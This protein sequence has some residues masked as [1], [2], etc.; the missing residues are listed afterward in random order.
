M[1]SAA[2]AG[3]QGAAARIGP[4]GVARAGA[5]AASWELRTCPCSLPSP[6]SELLRSQAAMMS[7]HHQMKLQW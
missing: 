1:A 2:G 6:S 7:T 5:A 4:A 3:A